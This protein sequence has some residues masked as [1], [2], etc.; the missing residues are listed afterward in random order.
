MRLNST[1]AEPMAVIRIP[2]TPKSAYNPKRPA[3]TLLQSQLKHLEWAV[4]PAGQR[5]AKAFRVKAAV[6]RGGSRGSHRDA[7]SDIAGA[8]GGTTRCDASQSGSPFDNRRKATLEAQARS[9]TQ[10]EAESTEA[11]EVASATLDP[12][13]TNSPC[14]HLPRSSSCCWPCSPLPRSRRRASFSRISGARARISKRAAADSIP[15]RSSD[16]L[17]PSRPKTRSMWPSAACRR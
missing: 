7:Q 13:V 6:H 4:R 17:S 11:G 1:S 5:T 3:G 10:A 12:P 8:G 15:R 14:A 16:A 9:E 2:K